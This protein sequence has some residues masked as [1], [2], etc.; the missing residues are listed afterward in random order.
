MFLSGSHLELHWLNTPRKILVIAK[1]SPDVL[2]SLVRVAAWLLDPQRAMHV[3][4][5]PSVYARLGLVSCTRQ[6]PCRQRFAVPVYM[7]T[8]NLVLS[9]RLGL[10]KLHLPMPLQTEIGCSCLH[11]YMGLSVVCKT[12]PVELH[13]PVPL[14]TEIGCPVYMDTCNLALSAD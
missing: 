10:F 5:E 11:G 8:W 2:R 3:Y 14:Q 6:S 13:L 12:R 4:V 1:P 7:D 9:A